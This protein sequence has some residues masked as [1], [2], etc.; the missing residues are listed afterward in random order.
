MADLVFTAQHGLY[1]TDFDSN[2]GHYQAVGPTYYVLGR[3]LWNPKN[4]DV[5]ALKAEYYSAYGAAAREMQLYYEYWEQWTTTTFTSKSVRA[6]IAALDE[7][8]NTGNGRSMWIVIPELYT[9]AV[10]D[11]ANQLL[12]RALAKCGSGGGPAAD[13]EAAC[14]K[15][16]KAQQYVVRHC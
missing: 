14:A 6:R 5:T 12:A 4:A 10:T 15:V 11:K 7:D 3:A 1:A 8:P 2:L 9:S 13:R 16:D